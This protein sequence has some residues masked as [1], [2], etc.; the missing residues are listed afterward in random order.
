ML[1]GEV[2]GL[3][4]DTS[5]WTG[6]LIKIDFSIY[7]RWSHEY[8]VLN[9]NISI[10]GTIFME[11]H[12]FGGDYKN[13]TTLFALWTVPT[14]GQHTVDCNIVGTGATFMVP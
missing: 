1:L 7:S 8:H 12:M 6:E 2:L 5:K 11:S 13:N 10:D 9:H 3:I 4:P 14:T